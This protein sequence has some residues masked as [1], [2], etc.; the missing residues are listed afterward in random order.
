MAKNKQ[1]KNNTLVNF[2]D[3]FNDISEENRRKDNEYLKLRTESFD[4]D[5]ED[6]IKMSDFDLIDYLSSY[7]GYSDPRIV[8]IEGK[9]KEV[10]FNEALRRM[11]HGD[12]A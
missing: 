10:A 3:V 2:M 4:S 5:C 1:D 9:L 8:E 6:I 12:Q 7:R 11:K